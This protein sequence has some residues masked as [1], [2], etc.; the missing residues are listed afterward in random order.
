MQRTG[1][2]RAFQWLAW[3]IFFADRHQPRHFGF[4]NGDFLA[5]PPGKGK[6]GNDVIVGG[7]GGSGNGIH[8]NS[9][10]KK[11]LPG[12]GKKKDSLCLFPALARV[13]RASAVEPYHRRTVPPMASEPGIVKI[14]QRSSEE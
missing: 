6:V 5:P 14:S 3:G 7:L 1:D 4:G 11:R 8:G 13:V 10:S 2:A 9:P 12:K